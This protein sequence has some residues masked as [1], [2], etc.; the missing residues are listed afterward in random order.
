[1]VKYEKGLCSGIGWERM[2]G[3]FKDRAGSLLRRSVSLE[4]VFSR[5]RDYK[6]SMG[7][8]VL[9]A[10]FETVVVVLEDDFYIDIGFDESAVFRFMF[11]F[12]VMAL[13]SE[14]CFM[15]RKRLKL[16]G[17]LSGVILSGLITC[18]IGVGMESL[19]FGI[20]GVFFYK[21]A[22]ELMAGCTFLMLVLTVYFSYRKG[23]ARFEEYMLTLLVNLL[24]VFSMYVI[25]LIGIGLVC[26][27][28]NTLFFGGGSSIVT[29]SWILLSGF[30]LIPGGIL[31]LNGKNRAAKELLV[32]PVQYVL[33]LMAVCGLV[34]VYVYAAGIL[35]RWE[36]PSNEIFSI[37]TTLFCLGMPVWMV[38]GSILKESR[39][40][41]AI[42]CMPYVFAPLIL[43]QIYSIAVRI[44]EFGL[45][46]G[47]YAG[48]MM[49][50]FEGGT[51]LCWHLKRSRMENVLLIMSG[52]IVLAFLMPGVNRCR[53][54]ERWQQAWLEKYY[55][56]A[57]KGESLSQQEYNR[58]WG[59]YFYLKERTPRG[60][61]GGYDDYSVDILQKAGEGLKD[62]QQNALGKV[63]RY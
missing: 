19:V 62:G 44:W 27:C 51:L 1:M 48:V 31:A 50:V 22:Q 53:L 45:T 17:L 56:A 40:S 42:A 55:Q 32:T 8:A 37:L 5:V 43:L 6:F 57:Q 13:F 58:M 38:A 20:K 28:V 30:F 36:F 41:R 39:Y 2:M 3:T 24:M 54:S 26:S 63:D 18:F 35:I 46:P 23:T 14:T 52:L 21:K 34:T 60:M 11:L 4:Q 16:L 15:G 10:L 9:C 47:R 25:L 33:S 12:G 49:V 7:T 29:V 59:A 61:A